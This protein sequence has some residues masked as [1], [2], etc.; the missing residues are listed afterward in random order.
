[1]EGATSGRRLPSAVG[2]V[3]FIGTSGGNSLARQRVLVGDSLN[4]EEGSDDLSNP[5]SRQTAC[6]KVGVMGKYEPESQQG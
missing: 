2:V 3:E 6:P 1:M 4:D 5:F